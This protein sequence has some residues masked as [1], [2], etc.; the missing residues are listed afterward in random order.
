MLQ[1]DRTN[2]KLLL[3]GEAVVPNEVELKSFAQCDD[4]IAT[5]N[6]PLDDLDDST[7]YS[8]QLPCRI[9]HTISIMFARSALRSAAPLKRVRRL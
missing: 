1:A 4:V 5:R 3:P 2:V 6:Q 9:F 7:T 8:I